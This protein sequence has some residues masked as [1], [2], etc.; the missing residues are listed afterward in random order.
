[1]RPCTESQHPLETKSG[2]YI[3]DG[4]PSGYH[5]WAFRTR[6]LQHQAKVRREAAKEAKT[7]PVPSRTPSLKTGE[8]LP[9][10]PSSAKPPGKT[11][12]QVEPID[13]EEDL[14]DGL[15]ARVAIES[16]EAIVPTLSDLDMADAVQKVLEGLRGEAFLI[17]RDIG[18]D[19]LCRSDGLEHLIEMVKQHVFPLRSQEASELFRQG[20]LRT[21]PLSRQSGEGMLS[22]VNRRKRWWTTLQE[23]DPEVRLSEAMRANLLVELSGLSKPEQLMVKTAAASETVAEYARVLTQHHAQV[24]M[25]EKLLS[26]KELGASYSTSRSWP[27]SPNRPWNLSRDS[28]ARIQPRQQG[29]L[30]YAADGGP[31]Y[32]EDSA[33]RQK[34][35]YRRQPR[36]T[37]LRRKSPTRRR[38][39]N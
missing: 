28:R 36:T 19:R 8:S 34:P 6:A 37:L 13:T 25:R 24:H 9:A 1:M 38:P 14:D 16:K 3:Y 17:A 32:Y 18:L 5:D 23:L 2:S 15:S 4:S 21:G 7:S 12:A 33:R 20:Q 27:Q 10:S 30:A 29:S 39:N 26:D 35:S 31:Q 22:Y 11:R